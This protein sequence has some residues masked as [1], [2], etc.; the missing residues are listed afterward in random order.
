MLIKSIL[1]KMSVIQHQ[2]NRVS[3]IGTKT[4]S[5]IVLLFH[6]SAR[7]PPTVSSNFLERKAFNF[8]IEIE[9]FPRN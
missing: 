2:P 9:V 8:G 7:L 3:R 5:L 6:S 4:V 1:L